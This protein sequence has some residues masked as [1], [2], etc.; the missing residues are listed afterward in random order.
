MID[1]IV[2]TSSGALNG[3][4]FAAGIRAG[5]KREM[6]DELTKAW[7]DRGQWQTLFSVNPWGLLRGRGLSKQDNL[8]KLM[9]D[10]V[11]PCQTEVRYPVELRII[12]TPLNGTL[13]S[14]DNVPATT[15]EKVMKFAD[16]D[17]DT[18]ESLDKIFKVV[19]AACS[20]PGLFEPVDID[21]LGFCVD[22]GAVNNAP[23]RYALEE[24]DVNRVIVPV[25]FPR[26]MEPGDWKTGFGLL[27][28]LIEI[29][30]NERLYR[31][32]KESHAVNKEATRL[33]ALC[34]DGVINPAQL[35]AV[36]KAMSLR[37]V[38]V[39]QIRPREGLKTSPFAGF[40]KKEERMRLIDQGRQAA[41]E[42]LA[43]IP[44]ENPHGVQTT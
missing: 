35:A 29:L 18:Q 30:I 25:P 17:F 19:S 40:F 31:D 14:I 9:R 3:L 8:L 43:Q 41:H 4:A 16:D 15:Y 12:L 37:K 24:S 39:T 7:V 6:V 38:E 33:E 22:G 32:L 42:T 36:K 2:A 23:I 34:A 28:H 5:R 26:V 13:G 20:F 1:R 11:K 21:G 10:L 27:N 44:A